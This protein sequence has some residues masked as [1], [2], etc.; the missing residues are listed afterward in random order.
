MASNCSAHCLF[1]SSRRSK[2]LAYISKLGFSILRRSTSSVHGVV[3]FFAL[4][5]EK[6]Q[7][8]E[9]LGWLIVF[10]CD[11]IYYSPLHT[12]NDG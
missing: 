10:S 2:M 4:P 5:A 7:Q 1:S 8:S 6:T 11:P 9:P 12:L 3:R